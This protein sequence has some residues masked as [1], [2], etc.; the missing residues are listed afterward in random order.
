M[1]AALH[2]TWWDGIPAGFHSQMLCGLFFLALVLWAGEPGIELGPL[3]PQGVPLQ[4]RYPSQFN[5]LRWVWDQPY[6]HACPS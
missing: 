1:P 4:S 2:L 6:S 5:C 3:I